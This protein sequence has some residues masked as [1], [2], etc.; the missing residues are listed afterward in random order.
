MPLSKGKSKAVISANIREMVK[1]GHPVKQAAAA[2]YS[3]ARKSGAD[4]PFPQKA[5]KQAYPQ[6]VDGSPI[7]KRKRHEPP[8]L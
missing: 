2:A 3:T 5:P 7:K 6:T 1:A 4:L 8:P